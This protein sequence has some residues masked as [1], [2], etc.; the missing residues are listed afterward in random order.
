MEIE[1]KLAPVSPETGALILENEP[2]YIEKTRKIKMDALYFDTPCRDLKKQGISLRLRREN[3][4]SVCCLKIR[5]SDIARQEFEVEAD[6]IADGITKLCTLPDLPTETKALVQSSELV[7]LF[8]SHYTRLCRLARIDHAVIEIACDRGKLCQGDRSCGISEVELELKEGKE[9]DLQAMCRYLQ[10]K[11]ALPLSLSTK[12][13]R[14]SALT[15]QAF[16][17]LPVLDVSQLTRELGEELFYSG[18]MWC[19]TEGDKIT[20]RRSEKY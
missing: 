9:E 1:V 6:T 15:E 8:E 13:G 14:A 17:A 5:R 19:K 2:F 7:C 20:C 12:A 3:S 4:Q 18:R 16:A 10:A 11:Y